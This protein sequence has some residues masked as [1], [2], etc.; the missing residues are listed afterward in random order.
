MYNIIYLNFISVCN[1][2]VTCFNRKQN[3]Y[4][5]GVR[6]A[7]IIFNVNTTNITMPNL[8]PAKKLNEDI[9]KKWYLEIYKSTRKLLPII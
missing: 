9:K 2:Y 7:K 3:I 1:V 4:L 6:R 8:R 5:R